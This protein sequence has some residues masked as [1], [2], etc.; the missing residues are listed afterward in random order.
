[1]QSAGFRIQKFCIQR[2]ES[3]RFVEP[4]GPSAKTVKPKSATR[5]WSSRRMFAEIV[6]DVLGMKILQSDRDFVDL[7][8]IWRSQAMLYEP[9][10]GQSL[11]V[12][13]FGSEIGPNLNLT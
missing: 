4:S 13:G 10:R 7:E 5:P 1:M 12:A 11:V 6:N 8:H 2:R 3:P 9:G